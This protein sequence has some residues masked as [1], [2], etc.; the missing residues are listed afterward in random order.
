LEKKTQKN[1]LFAILLLLGFVGC[2]T[3]VLKPVDY[4]WPL[5]NV[6]E[7]RSDFNVSS[8][9]YAVTLNLREVFKAENLIVNNSP[10]VKKVRIIRNSAGYYFITADKFKYVYVFEPEEKSL[11]LA[12]KI[13]INE[14]GIENPAFNQ[15]GSYIEL[16]TD[17]GQKKY[18]LTENGILNE[19]K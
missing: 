18:K 15:R 7:I 10:T 5:E 6:L 9:R 1:K 11:E 13:M 19:R 3:I 16:I 12:T 2:S 17:N 8:M 4:A 14:K